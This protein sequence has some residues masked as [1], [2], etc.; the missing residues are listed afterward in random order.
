[1]SNTF[2]LCD[3]SS[4]GLPLYQPARCMACMSDCS[5]CGG[6]SSNINLKMTEKRIQ[7]QVRVHESQ[8]TD[9]LGAMTIATNYL[10]ASANPLEAT[11]VWANRFSLR[12]QSDRREP[13]RTGSNIQTNAAGS[14]NY[15]N[16]PTR[17]NSTRST[18]TAN[19]PGAMTPG[20][21]GVDVKHGSYARYLG[22]LKGRTMAVPTNNGVPIQYTVAPTAVLNNKSYRFNLLNL[23]CLCNGLVGAPGDNKG[24]YQ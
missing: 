2:N 12:N 5:G 1:M 20:G 11:T 16:V 19:R 22:K 24:I 3:C 7:N 9:V 4:N 23:N 15:V 10:D 17:G 18:I 13:S 8:Y 21:Y 14:T 6:L